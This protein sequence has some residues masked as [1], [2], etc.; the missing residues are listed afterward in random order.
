MSSRELDLLRSRIGF[1]FQ[2][3]N[4]FPHFSAIDNIMLSPS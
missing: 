3:L 2:S 4:L 1:V